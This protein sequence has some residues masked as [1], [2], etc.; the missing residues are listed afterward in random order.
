MAYHGDLSSASVFEGGC[1]TD[2]FSSLV[3]DP[4]LAERQFVMILL[5]CLGG[6][7]VS[8]E[9]RPEIG[10]TVVGAHLQDCGSDNGAEL[11]DYHT[12]NLISALGEY[13]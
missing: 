7:G 13:S 3:G 11:V 1:D 8:L 5:S 4:H 10:D 6:E 2:E 12:F 9:S